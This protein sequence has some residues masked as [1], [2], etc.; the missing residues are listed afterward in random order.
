V[1][2]GFKRRFAPFVEE[3][4]KTHT[5]RAI[6]KRR[7]FR[8]GDICDCFVDS[9]QKTMRCIGRF[10]CVRVEEIAIHPTHQQSKPIAVFINGER[11]TAEESDLFFYRDGFRELT[12]ET[13]QHMHQAA[14]F[15]RFPDRAPF[16]GHLIHWEFKPGTANAKPKAS[17]RRAGGKRNA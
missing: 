12:G 1:L 6:G 17:K 13:Y 8:P 14:E 9:R 10:K 3:G 16:V 7:A 11:L 2:L 4:S 15:W 5:I